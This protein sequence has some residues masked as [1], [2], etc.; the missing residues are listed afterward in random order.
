MNVGLGR[1]FFIDLSDDYDTKWDYMGTYFEKQSF[2]VP[3]LNNGLIALY[4]D[5]E[6]GLNRNHILATRFGYHAAQLVKAGQYGRMVALRG[7]TCV[8]VPLEEV[9]GHQRLVP[10]DDPILLAARGI[11]VSLG[12]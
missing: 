4:I 3:L 9:A 10:L 6:Y 5:N 7:D 12:I 2:A 8:S 1:D 11:G